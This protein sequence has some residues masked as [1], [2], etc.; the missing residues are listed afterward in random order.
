MT[1]AAKIEANRR[2]A[3]CSTGPRSKAGKARVSRNAFRHGLSVPIGADDLHAELEEFVQAFEGEFPSAKDS[4]EFSRLVEGQ[5]ELLRARHFRAE[6]INRAAARLKTSSSDV[7]EC[8]AA[9]FGQKAQLLQAFDRYER[10][11]LSKRRRALSR[12]ARRTGTRLDESD[13][14]RGAADPGDDQVPEH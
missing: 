10:R 6:L 1:S 5:I 8:V 12:L 7:E 14:R 2:N 4:E 13:S 11:A 9:G 3:R